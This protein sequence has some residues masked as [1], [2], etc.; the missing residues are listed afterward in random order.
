MA[1]GAAVWY[2]MQDDGK[3][4]LTTLM[5]AAVQEAIGGSEKDKEKKA[6]EEKIGRAHV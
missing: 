4:A 5:P 1:L 2:G 3:N 6:A